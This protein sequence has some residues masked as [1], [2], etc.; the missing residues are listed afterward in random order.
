MSADSQVRF[1]GLA[2]LF[3]PQALNRLV[4]AHVAVV[5]LGGVGSWAVEAL[6]RSGIGRLTLIDLDEVCL[7]NVNRQLPALDGTI[8]R[9]KAEVLA[10]RVTA[11]HP[12]CKVEPKVEFF[13][14]S[15]AQR[16]LDAGFDGVIDAIDALGNKARLIAECRRRKVDVIACGAAGGR[17]DP[18]RLRVCDLAEASHDALLAQLRK[19]LR[20]QHGFPG[21]GMA[22][23]VAC[24]HSTEA[25]R[26]PEDA[27]C[28]TPDLGPGTGEGPLKLGCEW[29]YGSAAFVTGAFGLAAAGWM[30]RRLIG[31]AAPSH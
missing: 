13:T 30:I 14:D 20:R 9:F 11:I 16:L 12:A 22:S 23:G 24:V 29:G 15:S 25:P 6:A 5:G 7:S 27:G 4:H 17:L 21:A 1:A 28:P 26:R 31:T 19:T 8:G 2:R 10:E 3:G 18:T